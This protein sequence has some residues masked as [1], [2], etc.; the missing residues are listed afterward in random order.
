LF[1]RVL[2]L[3]IQI[4]AD[5]VLAKSDW[6]CAD[7]KIGGRDIPVAGSPPRKQRFMKPPIEPAAEANR[8]TRYIPSIV[9]DPS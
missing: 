7:L 4:S 9:A 3:R 2:V 5:G 1:D 6:A 8:K